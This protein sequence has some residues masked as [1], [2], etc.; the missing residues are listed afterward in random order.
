MAER[1]D[2]D[3]DSFVQSK[4]S[5]IFSSSSSVAGPL[6]SISSP[7]DPRLPLAIDHT[8]L[9]PDATPAQIDSLCD[10]AIKYGFKVGKIHTNCNSPLDGCIREIVI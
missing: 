8:L 1:T 3:W 7:T 6:A 10:E 2:A 9:K 5:D 4:I